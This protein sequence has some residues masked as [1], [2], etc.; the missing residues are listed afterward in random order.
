M[1]RLVLNAKEAWGDRPG[2]MTPTWVRTLCLTRR[3]GFVYFLQHRDLVERMSATTFYDRFRRVER[4]LQ[5][6]GPVIE[7]SETVERELGPDS[8]HDDAA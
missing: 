7:T 1:T 5:F 6:V 3:P 4:W 8:E 2:E